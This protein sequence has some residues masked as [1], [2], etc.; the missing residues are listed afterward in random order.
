MLGIDLLRVLIQFKKCQFKKCFDCFPKK[1]QSR[2]Y[3]RPIWQPVYNFS[4]L[5]L[6]LLDFFLSW[7]K[8]LLWCCLLNHFNYFYIT[9]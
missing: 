9:C 4:R 7:T 8:R 3:F 5:S 1:S 2:K 6:W